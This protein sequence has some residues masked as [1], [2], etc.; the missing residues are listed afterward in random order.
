MNDLFIVLK[1]KLIITQS[2]LILKN[3]IE[4]IHSYAINNYKQNKHWILQN[5][6]EYCDII[7]E[8]QNDDI[9]T[10]ENISNPTKVI[11]YLNQQF[12]YYNPSK[13]R[14]WT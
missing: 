9:K 10:I 7:I 11:D 12:Q 5:I 2:S 1:D 4:V 6:F 8:Q 14:V 13:S 3:D